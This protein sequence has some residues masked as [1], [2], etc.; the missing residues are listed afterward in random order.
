MADEHYLFIDSIY[1]M[2]GSTPVDEARDQYEDEENRNCKIEELG[3]WHTKP[4]CNIEL[5]LDKS[6]ISIFYSPIINDGIIP[7]TEQ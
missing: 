4:Y 1:W 6:S 5:I 3:I 2:G 7:H